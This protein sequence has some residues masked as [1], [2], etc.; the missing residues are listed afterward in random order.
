MSKSRLFLL[1]LA[2]LISRLDRNSAETG[3]AGL[4]G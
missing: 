3:N 4:G 2:L 1:G